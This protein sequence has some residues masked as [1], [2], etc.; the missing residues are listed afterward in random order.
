MDIY[1]P[2]YNPTYRGPTNPL[3]TGGGSPCTSTGGLFKFIYRKEQEEGPCCNMILHVRLNPKHAC[4][5]VLLSDSARSR[6]MLLT[7]I[8]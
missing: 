3:I 7:N 8:C 5:P 1:D 6:N 2:G 4:S